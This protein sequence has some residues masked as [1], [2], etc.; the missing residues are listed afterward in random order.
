MTEFVHFHVCKDS[1][2]TLQ[3]AHII[4]SCVQ[5]KCT[6]LFFQNSGVKVEPYPSET[7]KSEFY[8]AH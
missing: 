8:V 1:P 7:Q 3:I 5:I 6:L 2:C 4:F